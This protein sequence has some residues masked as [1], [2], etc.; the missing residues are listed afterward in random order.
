LAKWETSSTLTDS[1]IYDNGGK[2]G[3]G[4]TSPG[5]KLH[6]KGGFRVEDGSSASNLRL[7]LSDPNS[8]D[9]A[10]EPSNDTTANVFKFRPNSQN[11]S[12]GLRVYDRYEAD[13]ISLRHDSVAGVIE[14]DSDGGGSIKIAPEGSTVVEITTAGQVRFYDSNNN[15]Y[16]RAISTANSR[17]Y[18]DAN[19]SHIWQ[20]GGVDKMVLNSAGNVGIGTTS[21][22]V[23]LDVN[24]PIRAGGKITYTKS[25]PGGL[26]TTGVAVAGLLSSYN[27]SSAN[28]VFEMHGGT[29]GYQKVVYSCYNA[30]G[31]WNVKNV[32]NEGT[33]NMDVVASANASTIT[34]TFKSLS[35]TLAYTPYITIEQ[36]GAA[37]DTQ[38]L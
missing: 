8:V 11:E 23:K 33:N 13:Y 34:F 3:I 28:F 24:G 10:I 31:I 26:D 12:A 1:P 16:L 35:G 27:G 7:F 6:I 21:P 37:I 17:M 15:G 29:G 19:Y 9:F 5:D 18:I 25:Y 38:Y 30:S 2:I 36:I 20:I 14:T 32:I 4:T 22:L